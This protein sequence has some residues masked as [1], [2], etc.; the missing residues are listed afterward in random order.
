MA[1]LLVRW[2]YSRTWPSSR[3]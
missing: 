1:T 3:Y 2:F